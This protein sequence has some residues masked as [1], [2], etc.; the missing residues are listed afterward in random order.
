MKTHQPVRTAAAL[1][2]CALLLTAPL[3][4][5]QGGGQGHNGQNKHQRMQAP[6]EQMNNTDRQKRRAQHQQEMTERRTEM[7]DR[8]QLT[9]E[10][11]VIWKDMHKERQQQMK[12]RMEKRQERCNKR[13]K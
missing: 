2:A 11:R 7:A 3:A 9:D 4:V 1:M 6:C 12:Q 5:A 13:M 8:L 10:Q